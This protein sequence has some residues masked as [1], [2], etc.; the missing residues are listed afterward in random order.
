MH[1]AI[2]VRLE[3]GNAAK[4]TTSF[5][6]SSSQFYRAHH[7]HA[8]LINNPRAMMIGEYSR[9]LPSDGD[10]RKNRYDPI[11]L[12]HANGK[13]LRL[14]DEIISGLKARERSTRI[15]SNGSRARRESLRRNRFVNLR[16]GLSTIMI[17]FCKL[18][19]PVRSI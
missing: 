7:I 2:S 13:C 15:P 1:I 14:R 10:P 4:K 3:C 9:R 6:L 16:N 11:S 8:T 12:S 17:E 19:S 18:N 5:S